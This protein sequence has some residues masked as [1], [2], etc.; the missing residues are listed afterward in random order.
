MSRTTVF[1]ISVTLAALLSI[2]WL[3]PFKDAVSS[4]NDE[5]D[6]KKYN[7]AKRYYEKAEKYAPG[8]SDRKKLSFNTGDADYML[9]SFDNALTGFQEAVQSGDREVQK[10]AFFNAGNAYLKMGKYRE[11]I[12]SYINALKIDPGYEPAKKNIEYVL[13]KMSEQ[14]KDKKD[15]DGNNK[16]NKKDQDKKKDPG[17]N[18]DQKRG[19]SRDS[20]RGQNQ[21]SR[22]Q[23][24]NIL[25]AL[26]KS[27]VRRE[28][29]PS[30]ERR[31]LEKNW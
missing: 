23:V 8:D 9:E 7:N 6:M 21:M 29:G 27:Q 24:Q 13:K 5:Y 20:R 22:E 30:D 12:N 25:R 17:S 26:Q 18:K 11:A 1:R 15:K 3:D 16:D 14:D 4:G 28:Q 2:A 19:Q 31:H 10:K